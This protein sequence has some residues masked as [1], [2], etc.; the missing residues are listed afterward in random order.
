[1]CREDPQAQGRRGSALRDP[2]FEIEPLVLRTEGGDGEPVPVE[3]VRLGHSG[4]PQAEGK[5]QPPNL[6]APRAGVGVCHTCKLPVIRGLGPAC[7]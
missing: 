6:G 5:P 1:M 7:L 2:R 4:G 3:D